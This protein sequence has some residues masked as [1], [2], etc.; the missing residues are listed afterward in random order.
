[1]DFNAGMMCL[2]SCGREHFSCSIIFAYAG[3][4]LMVLGSMSAGK[5]SLRLAYCIST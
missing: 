5:R 1:M 2:A 4:D 3:P